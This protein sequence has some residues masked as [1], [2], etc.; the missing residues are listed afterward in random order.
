MCINAADVGD[1]SKKGHA[2]AVEKKT[3][4]L[5]HEPNGMGVNV[6]ETKLSTDL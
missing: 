6:W 2:S 5:T 3:S 4:Y 1:I